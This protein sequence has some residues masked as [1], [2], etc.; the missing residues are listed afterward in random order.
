MRDFK[1]L[2]GSPTGFIPRT[3][4]QALRGYAEGFLNPEYYIYRAVNI[5]PILEEPWDVNEIDRLLAKND[6][7]ADTAALLMTVFGRMVKSVDKELALFAAES[8]NAL[9]RRFLGRVQ[10]LRKSLGEAPDAATVRVILTEYR[11]LARLFSAQPVLGAFYLAEAR[12]FFLKYR[13]LLVESDLDIAIYIEILLEL[14][15]IEVADTLLS[16]AL[17]RWPAS[18]RLRFLAARLAFI[19]KRPRDVVRHLELLEEGGTEASL[20]DLQNFWTRGVCRD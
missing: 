3:Q 9:E 12:A 10:R 19:R 18:R 4:A 6:L 17:A 15:A 11:T 16:G 5:H 20:E 7:D 13:G 8:I 1:T 2:L 14:K